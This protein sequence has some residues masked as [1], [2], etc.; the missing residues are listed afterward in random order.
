MKEF[1]QYD[2][3]KIHQLRI[4]NPFKKFLFFGYAYRDDTPEYEGYTYREKV[5]TDNKGPRIV[6]AISVQMIILYVLSIIWNI[7]GTTTTHESVTFTSSQIWV[8]GLIGYFTIP[9]LIYLILT[10]IEEKRYEIMM[11]VE[12]FNHDSYKKYA[13]SLYRTTMHNK[14]RNRLDEIYK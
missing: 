11:M 9:S 2:I 13:K 8:I 1:E 14:I 12:D 10:H 4:F 3:T 5:P 6:F 7:F